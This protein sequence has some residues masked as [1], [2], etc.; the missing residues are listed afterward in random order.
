MI[1]PYKEVKWENVR[2]IAS[3]SHAH[4]ETQAQFDIFSKV[5]G[6]KH[7]AIS[8]YYPSTPCYPLDEVYET[9][10]GI[11]SSPNAEHHYILFDG[12]INP[13]LHINGLGSFYSSGS[14]RGETPVGCNGKPIKTVIKQILKQLQFPD[15]GGVTINHPAWSEISPN[16]ICRLLDMDDRVLGIE[17][18]STDRTAFDPYFEQNVALFDY[19]LMTGRRCWC[20]CV[21][22]HQGQSFPDW[23][24]RNVLLVD[25]FTE[26]ECL[27]AYREGRFYGKVL[28]SDMKFTSILLNGRTY[29][30]TAQ[31]TDSIKIII[32]G[33]ATEYAGNS[34]S[35]DIPQGATYVRSEG[36]NADRSDAIFSNPIMFKVRKNKKS[37]TNNILLY[38]T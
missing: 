33:V 9:P 36:W 4:S 19:A 32:D 21:S 2:H 27:K 34:I 7:Y 3:C 17:I 5:G 26:H 14:P 11:I 20:F 24:G 38:C 18:Y 29:T 23:K 25:N 37:S 6:L 16:Q 12:V 10:S 1:N 22:D 28:N 15:A 31:D 35:V 30:V 13:A 8:N